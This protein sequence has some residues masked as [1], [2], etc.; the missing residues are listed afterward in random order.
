MLKRKIICPKKGALALA[1]T[2]PDPL[3]LKRKAETI[4]LSPHYFHNNI[5]R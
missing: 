5:H 2:T 4:G 1:A 3:F